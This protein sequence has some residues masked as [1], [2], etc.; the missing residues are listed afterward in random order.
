MSEV[1][2]NILIT[3]QYFEIYLN[4]SCCP[5]EIIFRYYSIKRA[6]C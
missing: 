2:G 6:N 5:C 3:K 1:Y 4:E